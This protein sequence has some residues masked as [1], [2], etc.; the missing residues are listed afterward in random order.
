[1][2]KFKLIS[3]ISTVISL[4]ATLISE[5]ADDR[6]IEE[7]VNQKVTEALMLRKGK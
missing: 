3:I 7:T 6:I 2:K 1:M 5:L 4:L